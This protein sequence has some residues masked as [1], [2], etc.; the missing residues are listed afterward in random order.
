MSDA[1]LVPVD[2]DARTYATDPRHHVVLEAS[3][4]TGKTRVLVDRYLA[5]LAA[6]VDP[7]HVLAISA[8]NLIGSYLDDDPD[9]YAWLRART[10]IAVLG[11]S[12]YVYDLTGDPDAI[13]RIREIPP[14]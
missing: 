2:Q 11:G 7:R 3:A 12:I 6:G 10:P 5:L 4:G 14:R 1:T 8:N 9:T 13:R